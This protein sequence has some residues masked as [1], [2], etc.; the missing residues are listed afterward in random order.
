MNESSFERQ[1]WWFAV[2]G[3]LAVNIIFFSALI[4]GAIDY[5][6]W[7]PTETVE[8]GSK[9]YDR[10]LQKIGNPQGNASVS[11]HSYGGKDQL[12]N[13]RLDG[14]DL[15]EFFS[16]PDLQAQEGMWLASYALV[17]IS[18]FQFIVGSIAPWFIYGTLTAT[19]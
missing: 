15:K 13:L 8:D 1:L 9:R 10:P 14:E 19:S 18:F 6:K 4:L 17:A 5:L 7:P 11:K 2:G 3:I 12:E 16:R